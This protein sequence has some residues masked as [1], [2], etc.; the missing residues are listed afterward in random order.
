[1][2]HCILTLSIIKFSIM[3][4][5]MMSF[6]RITQISKCK[7]VMHGIQTLRMAKFSITTLNIMP[8]SKITDSKTM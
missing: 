2:I 7:N 8:F 5:S 3:I 6:S 1:M 4:L